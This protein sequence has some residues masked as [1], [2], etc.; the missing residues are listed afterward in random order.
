MQTI[1]NT[2]Q[3]NP[4]VLFEKT[5]PTFMTKLR[6]IP[7][8]KTVNWDEWQLQFCRHIIHQPCPSRLGSSHKSQTEQTS[9]NAAPVIILRSPIHVISGLLY[10]G[11]ICLSAIPS[12]KPACYYCIS[13]RGGRPRSLIN[14][15]AATDRVLPGGRAVNVRHWRQVLRLGIAY[16][17]EKS[18]QNK[19]YCFSQ[20]RRCI[21]IE[22]ESL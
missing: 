20:L 17:T 13:C 2:H 19:R 7:I 10:P 6:E 12:L 22:R 9:R 16:S 21:Y 8:H 11:K 3:T 1:Q 15:R 4:P 18:T 14:C 5:D